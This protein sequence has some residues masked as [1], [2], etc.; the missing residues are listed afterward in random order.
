[1]AS[2]D[3]QFAIAFREFDGPQVWGDD[4]GFAP[5]QLFDHIGQK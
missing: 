2:A 1:M 4:Y 3:E 5:D